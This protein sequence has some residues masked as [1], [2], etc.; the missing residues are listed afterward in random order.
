M[1]LSTRYLGLEL[2]N[3]V[4]VSSS[5]LTGDPKT[6]RQCEEAGAGAIVLK[7]LFEEQLRVKTEFNMDSGRA[8]EMYF[9]FPEA[10]QKVMEQGIKANMELYLQFVKKVKAGSA[11]PVIASINCQTAEEWPHFA[12]AIQE[13]GVDALE[14]NIGI[15]PFDKSVSCM[16]IEER[17]VEILDQVRKYVTIPVSI[18]LGHYFTNIFSIVHKLADA[19]ADGFVLFNRYFRPDIDLKT[20]KVVEDNYFSS[21]EELYEP[22]RWIAL[23]KQSGLQSDLAA[24]TGVHTYEGVVK[25]LLAGATVTQICSTLF[26]NGIDYITEIISGLEGWMTEHHFNTVDEF[27]GKSLGT[28]TLNASFERL[29]FINRNM[30]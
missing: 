6:I 14:L 8:S 26:K 13:V 20:L 4:V 28:Q 16:E 7:S 18:K 2:K 1:D 5:R 10:R 25:Q 15:F 27:R 12:K 19:G 11:I 29:Q 3:P 23:L 17:Y 21:P 24:S 9:W 22:L 30:E